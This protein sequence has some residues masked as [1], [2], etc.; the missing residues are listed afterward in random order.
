M[1]P[2]PRGAAAPAT[3]LPAPVHAAGDVVCVGPS[4]GRAPVV[5]SD[6]PEHVAA[7]LPINV[8]GN[9]RFNAISADFAFFGAAVGVALA[10][11]AAP[12]VPNRRLL[13]GADK[14]SGEVAA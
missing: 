10:I 3:L 6:F 1:R 14:G 7:T 13:P 4:V 8:P 12:G 11:G 2:I 9:R 5:P